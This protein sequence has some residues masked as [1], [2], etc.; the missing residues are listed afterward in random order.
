[1]RGIGMTEI[2]IREIR[3]EDYKDIF[4][5]NR[6]LGYIYD[7]DKVR[8]RI[9]YI[10]SSTKD[11]VFVA[12]CEDSVV[13][14]IHASPYE[15][16]FSDSLVNILGF[17]VSEKYR[18]SGIGSRLIGELEMW[19]AKNGFSGIRLVSGIDRVNAHMFYENHGYV[20]RKNQKN[21]VKMFS[22]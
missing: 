21:F 6:E 17:V 2:G 18:G 14:Y 8:E 20:N 22:I 15:L 16:L 3:A 7:M 19:A 9:E 12:Q 4:V 1:M 10:L 5:L 13:G 11:K